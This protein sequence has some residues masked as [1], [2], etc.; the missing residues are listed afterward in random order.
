MARS[1]QIRR[2]LHL[3]GLTRI[4][5]DLGGQGIAQMTTVP[6]QNGAS[7]VRAGL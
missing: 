5:H 7:T 4:Y 6:S 1:A 3:V 2:P